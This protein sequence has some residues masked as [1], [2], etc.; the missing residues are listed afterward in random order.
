MKSHGRLFMRIIEV[1]PLGVIQFMNVEIR[2]IF[3]QVAIHFSGGTCSVSGDNLGF[4][5]R[6]GS[7]WRSEMINYRMGDFMFWGDDIFGIY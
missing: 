3:M 5:F 1:V 6:M 4:L 7:G 2:V